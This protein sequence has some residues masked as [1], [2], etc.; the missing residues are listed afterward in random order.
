MSSLPRPALSALAS[1]LAILVLSPALAH[2]QAPPPRIPAG[3]SV[4]TV[5]VGGLTVEEATARLEVELAPRFSAPVIVRVAG[6]RLSFDPAQA[7]VAFDAAATARRALTATASDVTSVGGGL[8]GGIILRPTVRHA[9][10]PVRAYAVDLARQVARAPRNAELVLG[11]RHQR[12]R[13]ARLGVQLDAVAL[14]HRIDAVLDDPQSPRFV[15]Q[16][17]RRTRPAINANDIRAL[18]RTVI[19]VSKRDFKL[20]L[21]KN[22]KL[23]KSYSVAVGQRLYPTPEGTFH[24][25]NKQVDPIWSVPHSPWAGELAGTTVEGGSAANPLKARWMG[26]FDGVG[27]HGT[28]EDWSIGSAASHGCI[29]MHV[30]DVKDLYPRVPVGTTVLIR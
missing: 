5:D 2:A 29:R 25:Q 19:T 3:V 14:A 12:V 8:D 4:L 23:R 18:Y 16:R 13:R 20:R 15:E 1:A 22:L 9:H 10:L 6:R 7:R 27:I 26:I 30:W 28:G 21:F 17:V 24:I 11:V